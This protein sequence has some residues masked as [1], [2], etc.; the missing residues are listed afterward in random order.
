[1]CDSLLQER[2]GLLAFGDIALELLDLPVEFLQL[3]CPLAVLLSC[4]WLRDGGRPASVK[5]PDF[6]AAVRVIC[7]SDADDRRAFGQLERL[8]PCGSSFSQQPQN[9]QQQKQSGSGYYQ[10]L[11]LAPLVLKAQP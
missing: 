2:L 1:L 4:V 5:T 9:E 3:S 7:Q 11:P 6:P 8:C 10:Q